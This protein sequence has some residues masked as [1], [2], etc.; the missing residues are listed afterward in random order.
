VTQ[1][2]EETMA[3]PIDGL[4]YCP[5]SITLAPFHRLSLDQFSED[6]E[7]NVLGAV[8]VLQ[9]C[10]GNLNP[11]GSSIVLFSTVACRIG[12]SYHSSIAAAKSAVEG[13]VRSLAAE[14]ASKH[15]RVNAVA[16][17]LTDTPLASNLLSTEDKRKRAAQRHPLGRIG[18]VSDIAGAV[19]YL[20]SE[21]SSWV[22]G[23][24]LS[25]DGGL[26]SVKPL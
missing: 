22:T 6:Y 16:P 18:S 5:G 11:E 25:V 14:L 26:S 12:M 3:Q 2:I 10:L 15:I 7:I 21:A 17:S 23:Q 20:L 9:A 24:I 4:V 19:E 1:S 8:R 13:L